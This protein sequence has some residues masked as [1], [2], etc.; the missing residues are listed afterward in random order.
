MYIDGAA[1]AQELRYHLRTQRVTERF[2]VRSLSPPELVFKVVFTYINS[3]RIAIGAGL[4]CNILA[5]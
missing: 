5:Y 2:P 4:S 1:E 3:E